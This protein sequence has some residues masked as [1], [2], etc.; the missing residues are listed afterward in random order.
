[1]TLKWNGVV[2]RK[3]LY[4]V[5]SGHLGDFRRFRDEID[6]ANQDAQRAGPTP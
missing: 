1:M 4:D 3:V 2:Q 6:C 5:V